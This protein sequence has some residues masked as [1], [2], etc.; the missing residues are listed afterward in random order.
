MATSTA[1][2]PACGSATTPGRYTCAA[3]GAFLDGVAVAP[4]AW[5]PE[6]AIAPEPD[7]TSGD[8]PSWGNSDPVADDAGGPL[9]ADGP[10]LG[11]VEPSWPTPPD[12]LRDVE[13]ASRLE[14][15]SRGTSPVDEANA[16][17]PAA[18]PMTVA[19]LSPLPAPEPH[20]PAGS[21]LPP[22]ALL[23][24]LDEA[25]AN[26]TAAAVLPGA[27]AARDRV[28]PRD[29]LAAFGS[30]DRR[31]S[32]ARRL[33]AVG[34]AV[35]VAGFVLPWANGSVTNLLNVWTSVW[36]LAGGGSW[37]VALG[38]AALAVVASSSGRLAG[39]QLTLP[40]LLGSAF[41]LGLVWPSLLRASGRPIGVL[42]VFAGVLLLG[43]GGVLHASARHEAATP[44]V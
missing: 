33:I 37:L 39:V 9:L 19:G 43:A 13:W 28:N 32:T 41:L 10:T 35:A 38:A 7:A 14:A 30:A 22:S 34:A 18:S 36:G 40:A 3:C 27:A 26:G 2:C 11:P 29:W 23:T 15:A 21:W 6:A 42:V 8:V 44:D 12:V 20:V 5:E 25:D 16:E 1:A 31:R 17:T 4:R 24:G